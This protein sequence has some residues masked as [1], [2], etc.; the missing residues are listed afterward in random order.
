MV[1]QDILSKE[2]GNRSPR[3]AAE[4]SARCRVAPA[5]TGRQEGRKLLQRVC[6][7]GAADSFQSKSGEANMIA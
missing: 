3:D 4:A 6:R 7:T 1:D 5:G 2:R